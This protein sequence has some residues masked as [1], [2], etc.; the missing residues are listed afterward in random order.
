MLK[1]GIFFFDYDLDGRLD[2]LTANGHLEEEISKIQQSQ[3]YAQP[4]QT[5]ADG[6]DFPIAIPHGLLLHSGDTIQTVTTALQAGDNY[7][8]MQVNVEMWFETSV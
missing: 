4:A 7:S 5:A 2:V 3:T 8:F 6:T 1:F